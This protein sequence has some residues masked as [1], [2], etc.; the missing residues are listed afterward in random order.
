[1]TQSTTDYR[2]PHLPGGNSFDD[3]RVDIAEAH[4]IADQISC[5]KSSICVPAWKGKL[6][7]LTHRILRKLHLHEALVVNGVIDGWL[8]EFRM[9]WSDVLGGR[10]IWKALDFFLLAHDYRCSQQYAKPL[11]WDDAGRHMENWQQPGRVYQILHQ[12]ERFALHPYVYP[13]VWKFLEPKMRVLEY[14]CSSAPYYHCY[15]KFF[16]HRKQSWVLADIPNFPFHYG[17]YLYRN[18]EDVSFAT[19]NVENYD[20]PLRSAEKF[21]AIILTTVLEHLENPRDIVEYL[22]DRLR[23]GGILLYDYIRSEGT[24][25]DHPGALEQREECIKLIREQTRVE[26]GRIGD[27]TETVEQSVV[28]KK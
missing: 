22:L 26:V 15:R 7:L 20:D 1:M 25:L 5:E 28:R 14:G 13:P 19:I 4:R 21:D 18:D 8:Q 11:E 24:G 23:P 6:R 16:S 12:V 3:L 27:W 17:K 10:P 9:Y 2:V